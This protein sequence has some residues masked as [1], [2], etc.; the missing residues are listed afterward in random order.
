MNIKGFLIIFF[1]IALMIQ[2]LS[3]QTW[4]ENQR[5]TWDSD[6]SKNPSVALD[7]NHHINVVWQDYTPGDYDLYYKRSTDGGT[8]W[9]TKRLTWT[10]GYSFQPAISVDSTGDIHVVWEDLT[11]GNGEIF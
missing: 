3:A 4:S 10:P 1:G 11:P 7:S 5:L 6:G 2:P 8:T 9:T